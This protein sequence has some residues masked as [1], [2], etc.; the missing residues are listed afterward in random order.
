MLYRQ[1]RKKSNDFIFRKV[2][3][4][5]AGEIGC[6]LHVDTIGIRFVNSFTQINFLALH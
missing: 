3:N 5:F 1:Q 4:N 2:Y 6:F